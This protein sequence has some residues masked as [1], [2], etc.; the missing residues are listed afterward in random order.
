MNVPY[1]SSAVNSYSHTHA[2]RQRRGTYIDLMAWSLATG[3]LHLAAAAWMA[4]EREAP[5]GQ[6]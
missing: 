3:R 2:R 4:L 6:N 1:L 5:N